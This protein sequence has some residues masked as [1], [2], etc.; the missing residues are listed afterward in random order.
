M[1]SFLKMNST[2][3]S[4]G[5]PSYDDAVKNSILSSLTDKAGKKRISPLKLII[6]GT[7]LMLL[8]VLIS[9]IVL[10]LDMET[11]QP[12]SNNTTNIDKQ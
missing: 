11:L 2:D 10:L 9:W 3:Y 5:P 1:V 7:V 8:L 6:L 12:S 4:L